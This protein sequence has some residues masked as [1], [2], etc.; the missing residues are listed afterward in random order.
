MHKFL[1]RTLAVA[2]TS[3]PVF[4]A[5]IPLKAPPPPPAWTW[6]GFYI[7]LQAGGG[8][9]TTGLVST[10][11]V[12]CA[13]GLGCTP[14]FPASGLPPGSYNTHGPF[15]GGTLGYNWQINRLVLGIEGDASA[16]NIYG[17]GIGIAVAPGGGPGCPGGFGAPTTCNT[18]MTWFGTVTGR[19]GV[20]F[21]RA[22]WYAK[23]GA[24]FARFND[25]AVLFGPPL[26]AA[27]SVSDN[28]TGWTIGAGIE[29]AF[30]NSISTKFEYDYM[31]FGTKNIDYV[32]SGSLL[33][34]PG[35]TALE[36][37]N[38]RERVSILR[39]G[40]NYRFNSGFPC[41]Q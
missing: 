7:G 18:S 3:S 27:A 13:P 4:A 11:G 29:F 20:A 19:L 5:D 32:F 2:L 35:A 9:G 14:P 6:T 26:S 36:F 12:A 15:G 34:P 17:S 25:N 30:S 16:A 21:D 31:D 28:R 1:L 33:A 41:C 22:L 37:T 40:L 10:S 38:A 8:W 23:G 24:A 39:A